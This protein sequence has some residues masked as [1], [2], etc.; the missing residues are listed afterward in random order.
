MP[1]C[2]G[3]FQCPRIESVGQSNGNRGREALHSSPTQASHQN[4][5][6]ILLNE[7]NNPC[8]LHCSSPIQT[9]YSLLHWDT[10]SPTYSKPSRVENHAG[11]GYSADSR[12]SPSHC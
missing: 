2:R 10:D 12:V 4:A 8:P 3:G 7:N 5:Q 6:I 1:R 9:C 11:Q